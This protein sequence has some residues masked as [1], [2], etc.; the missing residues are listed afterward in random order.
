[1]PTH[2]LSSILVAI[3]LIASA[4]VHAQQEE[5]PSIEGDQT[6]PL[7]SDYGSQSSYAEP[8]TL[9]GESES[10][11]ALGEPLE[12]QASETVEASADDSQMS[13]SPL[14][15]DDSIT[16]YLDASWGYRTTR[17]AENLTQSHSDFAK[18]GYRLQD[19]DL[20]IENGDLKGFFVS[21]TRIM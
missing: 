20:Y 10:V 15:S 5:Q 2:Y 14:M 11:E 9:P 3:A 1:M 7:R 19:V 16:V 12:E 21:Y 6:T 13:G 17:A 8:D 4:T 18:R